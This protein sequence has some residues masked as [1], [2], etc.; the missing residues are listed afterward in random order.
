MLSRLSI[1]LSSV[2]A[3]ALSVPAALAD[4]GVPPAGQLIARD[5]TVNN[6]V[7][8]QGRLAINGL[9][10]PNLVV[11][12]DRKFQTRADAIGRFA[13]KL[14]YT[15][16]DC[17]VELA[18]TL[19]RG[20]AQV[21][22]CGLKGDVGPVGPQGAPGAKGDTGATG[23][24]GQTGP[25]GPTGVEGARGPTGPQG[26]TGQQG[27]TGAT[28][29]TGPQGP[30]GTGGALFAVIDPDGTWSRG[31]PSGTGYVSNKLGSADGEPDLGTYDV[32]FGT[33]DITGCG[34]VA[35]VGSSAA[36]G[37]SA[38]GYATVVRRASEPSGV[39]IQTYDK[40]GALADLGF[41]LLVQCAPAG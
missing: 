31:Y 1:P 15:S 25:Q 5:L 37:S 17:V 21:T 8:S 41:H 14:I 12:L 32:L 16:D 7:I 38:P 4:Q 18:T 22:G 10:R 23:A 27:A 35:S 28:G 29:A 13:F 26:P 40:T 6:I 30:A 3:A 9:T 34:Y 36:T 19:G 11:K 2:V 20:N 39:Y 33:T 24:T